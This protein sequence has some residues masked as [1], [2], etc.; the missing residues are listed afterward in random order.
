VE[1][2]ASEALRLR[3]AFIPYLY[4]MAWLN[5]TRAVSLVR[6]MYHDYPDAEAAYHCPQQYMFGTEL[7]AAPFVSRAHPETQL[8][9]QKVWL[10]EG[11]WYDFFTGEHYPGG[12]TVM[13]YGQLRDIPVFARAGAIVPLGPKVGWGGI[14]NPAELHIHVFAGQ[15]GSFTVY[16]D[17]GETTGYLS[18]QYAQTEIAHA[19]QDYEW[20]LTL[21]PATADPRSI[22][23]RRVVTL[24]CHGVRDPDQVNLSVGQRSI[25]PHMRYDPV[26]EVFEV[27][28]VEVSQPDPL[29]LTLGARNQPLLSRRDRIDEKCF[30]ILRAFRLQTLIKRS[31]AREWPKIRHDPGLFDKFTP[32]LTE[33]QRRAVL[34]LIGAK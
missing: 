31:I 4:S 1:R 15:D 10:P 9:R 5:H 7:L 12:K 32:S 14:E 2:V 6:P 20:R 13:R 34:D 11:E 21:H 27:H 18:G 3:H 22:P 30:A 24:Y 23:E 33:T 28:D 16:E 17:D 26:T 25:A 29:H 19:W 8:A